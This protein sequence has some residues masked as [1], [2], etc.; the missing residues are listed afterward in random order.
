[1][2]D[3]DK[4]IPIMHEAADAVAGLSLYMDIKA[5]K[6]NHQGYGKELKMKNTNYYKRRKAFLQKMNIKMM[7]TPPNIL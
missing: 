7:I 1:M 3:L 6:K 4:L 2:K 5:H